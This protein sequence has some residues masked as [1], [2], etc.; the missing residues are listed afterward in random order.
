MRIQ[1]LAYFHATIRDGPGHAYHLLSD[2]ARSKVHVLAFSA[3]PE[4]PGKTQLVIF[5]EDPEALVKAAEESSFTLSGPEHA[6]LCRGDDEL[7]ALA[8][9]HRKL[10]DAKIDLYASSGLTAECGRF[11]YVLHVKADQIEHAT[12]VLGL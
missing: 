9:I 5:P 2:L 10:F 4:G 8:E 1:P 3:I 6:L 7:G 11:A 12:H